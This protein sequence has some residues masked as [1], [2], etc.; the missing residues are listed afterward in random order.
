MAHTQLI[1]PPPV[2]PVPP[3]PAKDTGLGHRRTKPPQAGVK[4]PAGGG[5][6]P[7]LL[8]N[9][10]PGSDV[11]PTTP[12]GSQAGIHAGSP[13]THPN[14]RT[15]SAPEP[16]DPPPTWRE[17]VARVAAPTTLVVPAA[18]LL[19]KTYATALVLWAAM[20]CRRMDEETA[21]GGR[22]GSASTSMTSPPPRPPP[23]R[24]DP[25]HPST[26]SKARGAPG[27][28]ALPRAIA[29]SSPLAAL[30]P[31]EGW[32]LCRT[33]LPG[34]GL[35]LAGDV[36]VPSPFV[37]P[38]SSSSGPRSLP[39]SQ[40]L[41]REDVPK[42]HNSPLPLHTSPGTGPRQLHVVRHDEVVRSVAVVGCHRLAQPAAPPGEPADQQ[43]QPT[44]CHRSP[45]PPRTP[46]R[47]GACA[48]IEGSRHD[49][50][51][52]GTALRA[53]VRHGDCCCCPLGV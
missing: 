45:P 2:G 35:G 30:E 18:F 11:A 20:R 28:L 5:P 3:K 43:P 14:H 19:P 12:A 9:P 36:V 17:I 32:A 31:R 1:T 46:P 48:A 49:H 41:L 33:G 25:E 10:G 27:T 6:W 50:L 13:T 52:K 39:G 34:H 51:E 29:L 8:P 15:A 23:L 22:G 4:T 38:P 24:S 40:E 26:A 7:P 21:E 16:T 53:E 47:V 37:H 42:G 44:Q